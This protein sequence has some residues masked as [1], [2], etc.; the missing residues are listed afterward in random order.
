MK[1]ITTLLLLS[2]F[3]T[4]VF[5]QFQRKIT[6]YISAQYTKT[7]HDITLGNNPWGMGL[8]V[9]SFLNNKS[10]FKP[11]IEITS[12]IYLGDDKVFRADSTGSPF[13]SLGGMTNLFIGASFNPTK[14]YYL[15]FMAGP[16]FL[17]G[18]SLLGIKPSVGFYFSNKQ[19]LTGKISYIT[20]FN[21]GY[22]KKED[23]AS[24]SISLG[25]KLF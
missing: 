1:K 16:S 8:G 7:I 22:I 21:R 9:Q 20:I 23:F 13:N 4:Q 10:E 15:S 12:D 19:K 3:S 5:G 6:T 2:F 24:W 18:Q 14:N 11:T 25:V 17:G